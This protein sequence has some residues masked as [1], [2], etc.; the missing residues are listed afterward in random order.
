[1]TIFHHSWLACMFGSTAIEER[2]A[3]IAL[4]TGNPLPHC[5]WE[6]Q[7]FVGHLH[8]HRLKV[9]VPGHEASLDF[10]ERELVAYTRPARH[11]LVDRRMADT[12]KRLA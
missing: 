7:R 1:M 11:R 5:V 12:L 10:T 4:L 2:M 3:E 6:H 9:Q 8:A